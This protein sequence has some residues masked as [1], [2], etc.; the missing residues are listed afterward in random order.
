MYDGKNGPASK[1]LQFYHAGAI[2]RDADDTVK[3]NE[4]LKVI[5]DVGERVYN[6]GVAIVKNVGPTLV[7]AAVGAALPF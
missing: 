3:A 6:D 5:N 7:K 2:W 1:P 4:V